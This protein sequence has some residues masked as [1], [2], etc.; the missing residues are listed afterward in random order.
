MHGTRSRK[1]SQDQTEAEHV[2]YGYARTTAASHNDEFIPTEYIPHFLFRW[3]EAALSRE[4]QLDLLV[5]S[6]IIEALSDEQLVSAA[7][8][9]NKSALGNLFSRYARDIRAIGCR[10]L[11]DRGEAEDL[12]QELFCDAERKWASFDPSKGSARSWIM[13]MAH[14]AAVS[15]RRYLDS[16]RF[17]LGLD[18]EQVES[19]VSSNSDDGNHWTDIAVQRMDLQKLFRRLSENQRRT[20]ELFFCE[21]YTLDEIAAELGQSKGNVRHHYFRGLEKLRKEVFCKKPQA[22]TV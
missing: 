22:S 12:I 5:G 6:E 4:S 7:L 2:F 10:V 13:R 1:P 14:N 15:R 20:L 16:R 17:H 21:G 3:N 19:A 11:R 9:G 8:K 18:V